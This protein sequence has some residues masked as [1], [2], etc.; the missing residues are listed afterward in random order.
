LILF[1][2]LLIW[3]IGW[4]SINWLLGMT[5]GRHRKWCKNIVNLT[6]YLDSLK[7]IPL[8]ECFHWCQRIL[9]IPEVKVVTSGSFKDPLLYYK[10]TFFNVC[11]LYLCNGG[12]NIFFTSSFYMTASFIHPE[13][14]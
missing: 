6:F 1:E 10:L 2:N 11:F 12:M 9:T 3:I 7:L 14:W 8:Y 13:L 5:S 4:F